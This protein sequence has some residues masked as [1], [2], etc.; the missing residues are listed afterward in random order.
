MI[1]CC[2]AWTRTVLNR[3]VLYNIILI[4]TV[5]PFLTCPFQEDNSILIN[6]V[7]RDAWEIEHEKVTYDKKLGEGNFADV[8]L[9]TY[10]QNGKKKIT[11]AV[12]VGKAKEAG[13]ELKN[14]LTEARLMRSK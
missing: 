11:A 9:G 10:Q 6:A 14:A 4:L 13:K 1:L 12:K 7:P 5:L 3:I 2:I 8:Y